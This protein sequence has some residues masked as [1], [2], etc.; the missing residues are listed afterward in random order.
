M[1]DHDAPPHHH[2][3]ICDDY[4]MELNEAPYGNKVRCVGCEDWYC[5]TCLSNGACE[6]PDCQAVAAEAARLEAEIEK[7]KESI[8]RTMNI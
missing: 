3:N 7:N 6:D 1:I 8:L 5:D 2:C 4:G